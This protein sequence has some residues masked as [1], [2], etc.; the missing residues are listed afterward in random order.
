[1][2]QSLTKSI[3]IIS[4]CTALYRD[5][6]LSTYGLNAIQA[7]YLPAVCDHPGITQEQIAQNLHVNRSNVTRQLAILEEKGL[8]TRRRSENDRRSVQVFPTEKAI[9]LLPTVRGVF[10]DWR[11][12]LTAELSEEQR[13]TLEELLDA[14]SRKAEALG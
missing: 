3:M 8:I 14:L 11:Q 7:P 4:R 5:K 9:E 10:H 1:M 13:A 12:L 2:K 6:M